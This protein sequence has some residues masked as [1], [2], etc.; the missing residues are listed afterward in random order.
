MAPEGSSSEE[1]LRTEA[2]AP[3]GQ[4]SPEVAAAVRALQQG[5]GPEAFGPIYRALFPS[6]YL[7]FAHQ[8]ALRDEAEDLAQETLHLAFQN[9]HQYRGA[10]SFT[11][12]V[13]KI[14]EHLWTNTVK[15]RRA[16][17]RGPEVTCLDEASPGQ[18][19][20]LAVRQPVFARRAPN[21]EERALAAER[22]RVLRQALETL[23]PGMRRCMELR[24][25]H[26]FKYREIAEVTGVGLNAVRSQLWEARERLRPVLE[27]YFPGGL[28]F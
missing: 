9:L 2:P 11:T 24:L 20:G 7:F 6:L 12:W 3:R 13:R 28:D 1:S 27:S 18:E 8:S 23:P 22:K 21:P 25:L 4:D 5:A 19:D 15:N 17:K 16:L 14:G 10:G 26:D